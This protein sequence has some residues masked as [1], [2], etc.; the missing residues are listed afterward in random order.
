MSTIL[1][2]CEREAEEQLLEQA[3]GSHGYR[4]LKS[5]DGLE[6]LE[7]ARG[8]PP[9]LVLANVILPKMDGV[10]LFRK[11][12][13]DE[14]LQTV[15]FIFFSARRSDPKYERFALELGAKRF[16]QGAIKTDVVL[17]A[18]DAVLAE[19]QEPPPSTLLSSNEKLAVAAAPQ[20]ESPN[21][22]EQLQERLLEL[23]S[24]Q[25]KLANAARFRSLF[26]QNPV[27]MWLVHKADQ[28]IAAVNDA[29]LTLF[30]YTR[31]EFI[32][33]TA[34]QLLSGSA[35]QFGTTNVVAY[36]HKDNRT[37]SLLI[38]SKDLDFD[39]RAVEFVA[40]Q[41]VGYRVRAER[42]VI[43]EAQRLRAEF[44][45]L[46]DG[47]CLLDA[48]GRIL[49]VNDVFCQLTGYGKDELVQLNITDLEDAAPIERGMRFQAFYRRKDASQWEADV[50]SARI[51]SAAA[52]R[53]VQLI[54]PVVRQQPIAEFS[55]DPVK[56]LRLG[57]ISELFRKA[58]E[59]DEPALLQRIAA[60][61]GRA[62]DCE[63][64]AFGIMDGSRQFSA[65]AVAEHAHSSLLT[66]EELPSA[67]VDVI[68]AGGVL[69]R[70]DVSDD[71]HTEFAIPKFALVRR[72]LMGS[73]YLSGKEA[74]VLIA[75]NCKR[76]FDEGDQK[77]F[78][79]VVEITASMLAKKRVYMGVLANWQRA[80][81]SVQAM[82]D[83]L[84]RLGDQHDPHTA[85]S[86]SR[87]AALAV[88][89]ARK[90]GLGGEQQHAIYLAARLHDIGN[91]TI[92][93][94]ILTRP[95]PLNDYERALM[96]THAEQGAKLLAGV[97]LGIQVAELVHQHHE[98]LNGSGYPRGLKQAEIFPEAR[99]IA[100]ADVVEAMCS[101]RPYRQALGLEFALKE[102]AAGSRTVYD[103]DAVTACAQLFNEGFRWPD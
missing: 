40:A 95:Q 47:Y 15:P 27:A 100:V 45:A 36:K 16:L 65:L 68:E 19:E 62:F 56:E 46:P 7:V 29:A 72:Y 59:I 64:T 18:I 33:L 58:D 71:E 28:K 63:L 21:V 20:S 42:K 35:S 67:W 103:G 75:A 92:P 74:C 9:H 25:S 52:V 82:V 13:Q 34:D 90:L 86:S 85:N 77:D 26:E 73:A 44:A 39:A 31:A 81:V 80:D 1:I 96:R 69:V 101:A 17:G 94:E 38:S 102:I 8:E 24:L 48:S 11:C 37:L 98:R 76:P 79:A 78:R 93:R 12:K 2:A 97:D 70:N 91:I 4:V 5:R 3:L 99:I 23:E 83:L 87:V 54:R 43:E 57:L 32:A 30:G 61:V 14:R 89:I 10:A 6:A 50:S 60:H 55:A 51:D 66:A 84:C 41:D 53:H 22:R 88:A 49:E